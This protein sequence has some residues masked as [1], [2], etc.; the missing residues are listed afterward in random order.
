MVKQNQQDF[1]QTHQEKLQWTQIN[2]IRKERVEITTD[3]TKIQ[4]IEI[5]GQDEGVGRYTVPLRTSK[6]R[7][8]TNL[9]TKNNQT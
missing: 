3:S 8:A 1:N 7:T 9:K 6:R 2:N 4:T 5:S